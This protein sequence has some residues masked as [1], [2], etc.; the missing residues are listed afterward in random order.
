MKERA[1]LFWLTVLEVLG[2]GCLPG[3]GLPAGRVATQPR[4]SHRMTGRIHDSLCWFGHSQ[5][6]KATRTLLSQGLHPKALV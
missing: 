5:A 2:L 4:T 1:A 6:P 3:D